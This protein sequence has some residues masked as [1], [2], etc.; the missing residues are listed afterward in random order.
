MKSSEIY[1][2]IG[3]KEIKTFGSDDFSK[4]IGEPLV[5]KLRD[6]ITNLDMQYVHLSQK[7]RDVCIKTCIEFLLDQNIEKSGAHRLNSWENG[8][9]ENLEAFKKT[10]ESGLLPEYFKKDNIVR[11]N[12]EWI[13]PLKPGFDYHFLSIILDWLFEK[14]IVKAKSIYEFGCGTGHHLL[15]VR[16]FN[17]DAKL[18]GLDWA[19]ASQE[20][21]KEM[22]AKGLLENAIG[23]NFDFFAPD[24]SFHLDENSVIYTVGALEQ[25]GKDH[26]NFLDY[27][28]ENKPKICFHVEPIMELLDPNNLLDF[29]S[30]EYFKKRNYLKNF[31]TKLRG[32]EKEGRVKIHDARRTFLGAN[33]YVDHYSVLVWSPL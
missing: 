19:K 2:E 8:W 3:N 25:V 28:L 20:I 14:Y 27:L 10:G 15:R 16:E 26:G 6:R 11:L 17:K 31:L 33:L 32:L 18:Y 22:E 29:I 7:E 21:I 13:K 23:K 24:K 5:P 1:V 4:I 30:I 9:G 12:Q